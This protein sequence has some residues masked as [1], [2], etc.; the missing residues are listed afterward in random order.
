MFK[1]TLA[2]ARESYGI[3]L[4]VAAMRLGVE[5]I[6]YRANEINPGQ[7]QLSVISKM[8][9]LLNVPLSIIYPGCE[10]DYINRVRT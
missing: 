3:A 6:I 10:S 4:G 9:K 1:I 7:A 5:Q 2:M 8:A